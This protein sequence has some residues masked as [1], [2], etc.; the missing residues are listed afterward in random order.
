MKVFCETLFNNALPAEVKSI[1]TKELI[2]T[3]GFTQEEVADK[4]SMTQ[5]AASQYLS[6]A[7][8]KRANDIL[9][10]PELA[11]WIKKLAAEIAAGNFKLS[12]SRC[13]LCSA[14]KEEVKD[15]KLGALVCLLE[16][17]NLKGKE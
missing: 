11:N 8:G 2:E 7:R 3:Y 9:A 5:P 14:T 1:I 6:G 15:E 13:D 12:G 16:I 10:N 17:Y 4:L